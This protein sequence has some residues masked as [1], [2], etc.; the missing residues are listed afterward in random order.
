MITT[1]IALF[2]FLV[3]NELITMS[4]YGRPLKDGKVL[5]MIEQEILIQI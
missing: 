3:F 2:S 5:K 1:F 4:V